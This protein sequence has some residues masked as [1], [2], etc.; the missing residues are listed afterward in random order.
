[1]TIVAGKNGAERRGSFDP[2]KTVRTSRGNKFA[3]NR[4]LAVLTA[5]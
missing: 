5:A 3:L 1:M 2:A 4:L